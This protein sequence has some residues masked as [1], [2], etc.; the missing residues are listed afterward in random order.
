ME[1][2]NLSPASK[3]RKWKRASS[4]ICLGQSSD[5]SK[6]QNV[7]PPNFSVKLLTPKPNVSLLNSS[8]FMLV[9]VKKWKQWM[10]QLR[11][12]VC[13]LQSITHTSTTRQHTDQFN[14]SCIYVKYKNLLCVCQLNNLKKDMNSVQWFVFWLY[15]DV[16]E[17]LI[18]TSLTETFSLWQLN[19]NWKEIQANTV[20]NP[21]T[22]GPQLIWTREKLNILLC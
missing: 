21:F 15:S 13:P 7:L 5:T 1:S 8:C 20:K 12:P 18:T 3:Q 19:G 4:N 17:L 9:C 6:I 10:Q 11:V 2:R 14:C 16:S 22:F